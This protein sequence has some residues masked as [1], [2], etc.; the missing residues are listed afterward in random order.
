ME[1]TYERELD[2]GLRLRMLRGQSWDNMQGWPEGQ[3]R[4]AAFCFGTAEMRITIDG[5]VDGAD[6]VDVTSSQFY[7]DMYGGRDPNGR[8][9]MG[10]RPPDENSDRAGDPWDHR[11]CEPFVDAILPPSWYER[12]GFPQECVIVE[13]GSEEYV[14][15]EYVGD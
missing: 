15:E 12:Y 8:D 3:W 5:K 7:D 6:V 14:A 13:D 4:S 2:N 1:L 10:R 11:G 9:R